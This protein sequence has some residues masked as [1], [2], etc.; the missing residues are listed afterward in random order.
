MA[1]ALY[2][3][4]QASRSALAALRYLTVLGRTV[5]TDFS[6]EF[7]AGVGQTINVRGPVSVGAA[8]VYTPANRTNRDAIVFDDI[9]DTFYPV[10]IQ[11]QVYKAVRLPDD[12]ATFYL[13]DLERQVLV[14]QAKSVA[15]RLNQ[16]LL[17]RMQGVSPSTATGLVVPAV[18]QDG[19]NALAVIVALRRVLNSR[20]VPIEDRYIAVGP[21]IEAALL[22][23][24]NLL[25]VN[26]S[27]SDG[28]L[29][30]A[31]IGDLFGFTIIADPLLPDYYGVAYNR[32]AFAL[33]TRPS[34]NPEGAAKSATIAQDGFALRWLEHYN[35]LQLEDQ[36]VVDTF[37]GT[38]IL[39]PLRAVSFSM[40]LTGT[41][42]TVA[43]ASQTLAVGATQTLTVTDS[44]GVV[45]P[46]RLVAWTTS[47]AARA[48]V[49][50]DGVVTAV[51]T[52]AAAT[53]TGTFQ[54]K[55]GTDAVTVS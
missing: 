45:I 36:S 14:P 22:S 50:A 41:T 2:T 30:R 53:I 1:N 49:S 6:A 8:R 52:G 25:K 32:D 10:T 40:A 55:T 31:T 26:E 51:A 3:P 54:T 15:D 29:R 13:V 35:P 12:F 24:P 33:A 37:V 47:N 46:N 16:Y 48:T 4:A 34:K 38:A 27:G 9:T 18:A 28:A 44:A 5:R 19:S 42:I 7:V 11:D 39:D 17:A 21:G 43:P 20:Q 23:V